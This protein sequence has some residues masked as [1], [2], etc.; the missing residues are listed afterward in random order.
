MGY[1]YVFSQ[2]EQDIILI[3]QACLAPGAVLT[4]TALL[5]SSMSVRY[6]RTTDR[7]RML[8]KESSMPHVVKDHMGWMHEEILL[9]FR[10]ARIIRTEIAAAAGSVFMVVMTIFFLFGS[11]MV[12]RELAYWAATTFCLSLLLLIMAMGY[13]ILDI[14][15]SLKALKAFIKAYPNAPNVSPRRRG[16]RYLPR[17][18]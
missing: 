9:L 8:V 3:L 5:L 18:S 11:Q 16:F 1:F 17:S 4:G 6:G 2:T 15:A 10:R 14:L 12:A 7:I 13:F